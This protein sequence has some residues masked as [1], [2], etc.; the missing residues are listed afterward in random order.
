MGPMAPSDV[1]A[2]ES[3]P[4]GQYEDDSFVRLLDRLM[5]NWR[6]PSPWFAYTISRDVWVDV[7]ARIAERDAESAL[8]GFKSP[9]LCILGPPFALR[10]SAP[11]V[12]FT[13]RNFDA[14]VDS[15]AKR[16]EM[17]RAVAETIQSRYVM[18]IYEFSGFCAAT[19]IPSFIMPYDELVAEPEAG[20][21][22]IISALKL[23]PSDLERARAIQHVRPSLRHHVGAPR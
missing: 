19:D 1:S 3:N 17:P 2:P 15:L 14:C 20:V 22:F 8:W 10:L 5:G 11:S 16:D 21:D 12:I 7:E 13:H 4:L 6:N 23:E 9:Q 18:G